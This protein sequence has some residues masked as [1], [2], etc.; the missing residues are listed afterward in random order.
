M[1]RLIEFDKRIGYR[2]VLRQLTLPLESRP[3]GGILLQFFIDN[4]GC[5]P[6]YRPYRLAVRFR[7]G[8]RRHVVRLKQD[9]RGWRPG[10]TWFQ[11]KIAVPKPL[12]RGE[13]KVDLGIVDE[14]DAPKVRFAMKEL[15]S[16]GW[17]P[18]TSM[19][20]AR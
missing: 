2:F 4:V 13:V 6:I 19:D 15:T 17:H 12:A 18:V 1:D 10:H 20:V 9:I 14:T 11:E 3:G 7:Q 5:A 16:D 8:K